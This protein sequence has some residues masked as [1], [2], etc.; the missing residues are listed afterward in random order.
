MSFN[1]YIQATVAQ[2]FFFK[3]NL[4]DRT[5]RV[6][7]VKSTL[8]NSFAFLMVSYFIANYLLTIESGGL[9][10]GLQPRPMVLMWLKRLCD[11]LTMN[12][13]YQYLDHNYV[14]INTY[15]FI[16]SH[17]TIFLF[18]TATWQQGINIFFL[19]WTFFIENRRNF[20]SLFY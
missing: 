20:R 3:L 7:M 19:S 8:N 15:M 13:L 10:C 1:L 4:K 5:I 17:E 2:V 16:L 6:R 9:F 12:S 14:D 18:N 11:K